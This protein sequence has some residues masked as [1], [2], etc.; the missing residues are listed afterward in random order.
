MSTS[1][2][3]TKAKRFPVIASLSSFL[4]P[5]LLI[6]PF[7]SFGLGPPES[8]SWA[9]QGVVFT[10]MTFPVICVFTA[11]MQFF[12]GCNHTISFDGSA[13]LKDVLC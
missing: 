7:L 1:T 12:N 4:I 13:W 11:S 5:T 10:T 8:D 3:Q 9:I 6:V 2:G